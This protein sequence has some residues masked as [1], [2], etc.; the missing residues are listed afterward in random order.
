MDFIIPVVFLTS[1]AMVV[2]DDDDVV[3]AVL[4]MVVVVVVDVGAIPV[5]GFLLV[6]NLLLWVLICF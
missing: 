3:A 1:L 4:V 6:N 5:K 2:A